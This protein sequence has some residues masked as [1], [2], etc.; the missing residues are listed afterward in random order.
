MNSNVIKIYSSRTRW[1]WNFAS[2]TGTTRKGKRKKGRE[3][4][5]ER[6][7]IGRLRKVFTVASDSKTPKSRVYISFTCKSYAIFGNN[8]K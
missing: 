8:K 7:K 1:K 6:K 4:E 5:R 2:S 3:G